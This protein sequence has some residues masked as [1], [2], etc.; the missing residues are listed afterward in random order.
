MRH[1]D[2]L[3]KF[4]LDFSEAVAGRGRLCVNPQVRTTIKGRYVQGGAGNGSPDLWGV[5]RPPKGW[6]IALAIEIKSE[7]DEPTKEQT[8]WLM[9]HQRLGGVALVVKPSN[10]KRIVAW[11]QSLAVEGGEVFNPKPARADVKL[12]TTERI[13][14]I[15]I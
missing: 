12:S 10:S 7:K 8:D 3:K 1:P 6:G 4:R 9:N 14:S 13:N 11:L 2:I 15:H 5:L